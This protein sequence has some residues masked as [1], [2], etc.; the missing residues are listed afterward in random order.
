MKP[1][2][3]LVNLSNMTSMQKFLMW[4]PFIGTDVKIVKDITA[5]LKVRTEF[6]T[7]DWKGYSDIDKID[8]FSRR[9]AKANEWPNHHFHPGDPIDLLFFFTDGDGWDV[10]DLMQEWESNTGKEFPVRENMLY[11][12]LFKRSD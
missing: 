6:P 8:E 10:I 9:L 2:S 3:S 5:Q 1:I 12:D 7:E 11:G 4:C